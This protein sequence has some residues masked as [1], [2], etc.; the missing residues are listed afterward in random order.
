MEQSIFLHFL[1]SLQRL[2]AGYIPAAILGI[3]LGSFI[4]INP[5]V[6]KIF[7]WIIQTLHSI[8]PIALLPLALIGFKEAE[9]A[10]IVVVFFSAI[11]SIILNTAIG[12]RLCRQQ[13]NNFKLAINHIFNA[14]RIGG[15]VAWFAVIATEMLTSNKGLGFVIWNGYKS[16]NY[17]YTIEGIIYIGIIG[18]LLDQLLEITGHILSQLVSEGQKSNL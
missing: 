11:W 12:M 17:N 1:T 7:K 10:A 3:F 15:W 6:Y 5:L 9:A 8:T 13:N 14:L 16:G 18:F 2:F 4:G